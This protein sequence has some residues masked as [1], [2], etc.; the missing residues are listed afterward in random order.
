MRR[1]NVVV[2]SA[3]SAKVCLF[4]MFLRVIALF[5]Q[6]LRCRATIETTLCVENVVL[7]LSTRQY[8]RTHIHASTAS[9]VH[10]MRVRRISA[11]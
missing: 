9:S 6:V 11:M 5:V 2:H 3:Q 1:C 8:Y 4:C 10:P 7:V